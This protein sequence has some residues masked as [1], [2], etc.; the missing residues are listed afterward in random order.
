MQR[1]KEVRRAI[2]KAVRG[3]AL[4]VLALQLTCNPLAY[5]AEDRGG[6]GHGT[7]RGSG[8]LGGGGVGVGIGVVGPTTTTLP[9]G[10]V[11]VTTGPGASPGTANVLRPRKP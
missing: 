1:E 11:P 4:I 3:V 6:H 7:G 2:K 5:A 10:T 8:S 9:T